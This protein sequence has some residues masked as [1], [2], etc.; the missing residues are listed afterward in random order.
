ME[1]LTAT[2]AKAA[3]LKKLA[4]EKARKKERLENLKKVEEW[5]QGQHR[6]SAISHVSLND[7]GTVILRVWCPLVDELTPK[8]EWLVQCSN[9]QSVMYDEAKKLYKAFQLAVEKNGEFKEKL[10]GREI[11]HWKVNAFNSTTK[12]MTVGCTHIP[13]SEARRIAEQEG[14]V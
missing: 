3:R 8:S 12:V 10:I 5:K 14:W 6:G 11:G 4:E 7:E 13:Y 9:G 2:R 1:E